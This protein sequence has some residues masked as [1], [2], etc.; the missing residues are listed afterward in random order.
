MSR[1]VTN[2][3]AVQVSSREPRSRQ[4]TG[5]DPVTVADLLRREGMTGE[6]PA[7]R[8]EVPADDTPT[9]R[10]PVVDILR[11]E[12]RWDRRK[13]G[14]VA[15]LAAGVTALAGIAVTALTTGQMHDTA[16]S[17]PGGAGGGYVPGDTTTG[18]SAPPIVGLPQVPV[19]V[20]AT[21]TTSVSTD[22]T[23]PAPPA[24]A[25]SRTTAAPPRGHQ[26]ASSRPTSGSL[27]TSTA[28]SAPDTRPGNSGTTR[29][30]PPT[31]TTSASA[32]AAQ[33]PAQS[34][35]PQPPSNDTGVLGAVTGLLGGI[36]G[37]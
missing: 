27:G 2:W 6:F 33:P 22:T 13:A 10:I 9:D 19:P 34:S 21:T 30:D 24:G 32:P 35:S 31:T 3:E 16:A 25:S 20:S 5:H 12:G 11:R 7:V 8:D 29:T 26:Q 23:P 37:H 28:D 18:T 1:T 15:A 4:G 36:L 14:R 17:V